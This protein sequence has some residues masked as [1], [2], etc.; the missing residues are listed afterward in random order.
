M[1]TARCLAL[2]LLSLS[3]YLPAIPQTSSQTNSPAQPSWIARSNENAQLLL[4]LQAKYAPEGASRQGIPGLDEQVSQFPKDRREKARADQ[5]M[6]LQELKR[7]LGA[8]KDPLVAQ[9]LEIMIKAT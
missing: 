6:V 4:K 7:R 8:E 5:Q 3:M 9:D 2:L 1:K